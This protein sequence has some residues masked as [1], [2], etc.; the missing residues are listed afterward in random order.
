MSKKI[1]LIEDNL[2]MRENIQEILELDGYIVATAENG[3]IGID[4]VI[5]EEPDLILCDIMMPELDGYGVLHVISKRPETSGI[6]FIFLTAKSEKDDFRKGMNMGADDYLT[7]PFDDIQLLDAVERRLKRIEQFAGD[8]DKTH[9]SLDRFLNDANGIQELESLKGDK[10]TKKY[11]K[12]DTVFFEGDY[13]NFLYFIKSGKVKTSKMNEDGKDFVT[14]LFKEGDFFGFMA[15]IRDSS[16]EESAT[17]LED[18]EL[19]LIPKEDF[20]QLLHSSKEVSNKFIT[21]LAGSVTEKQEELLNLAYDSVRKRVAD[22]LVKLATTY[23]KDEKDQFSMA[24]SRDDLAAIVGT[25]TESV[26]RTLSEFKSDGY[27]S[28]KGSIITVL[29]QKELEDFKY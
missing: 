1:V 29:Q 27:I 13:P 25:S 7:K 19:S 12:K 26:I 8:F 22:A 17:V 5:K 18:C 14:G 20:V 16:H 21:M 4:M 11:N 2:E 10:R 24:I 15:L 23:K 9:E 3:K 28:I 6:P